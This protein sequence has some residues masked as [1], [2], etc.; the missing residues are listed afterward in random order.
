ML[1]Y[2]Y[3]QKQPFMLQLYATNTYGF[4]T[5]QVRVSNFFSG[6]YMLTVP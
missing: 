6:N 3:L 4:A 2:T 1:T 5:A